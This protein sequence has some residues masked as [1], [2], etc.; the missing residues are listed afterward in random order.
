M[1]KTARTA[2]MTRTALHVLDITHPFSDLVISYLMIYVTVLFYEPAIMTSL[3]K[4]YIKTWDLSCMNH[5]LV[6]MY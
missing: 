6:F 4:L 3:S 5:F 2:R 1:T